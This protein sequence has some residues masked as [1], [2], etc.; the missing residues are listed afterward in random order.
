MW[1]MSKG[2]LRCDCIFALEITTP[3]VLK[4]MNYFLS[5]QQK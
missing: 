1:L 2:L 4:I 5:L 3:I